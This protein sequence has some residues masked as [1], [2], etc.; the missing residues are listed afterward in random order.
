LENE[1]FIKQYTLIPDF[2]KLGYKII[3]IT[4]VKV[5]ETIS[6]EQREKARDLAKGVLKKGQYEIVM[7]ERGI[8]LGYDGVFISYHRNYSEYADLKEWFRRFEFLEVGRT[9]SFLI[10]LEDSV[11]YRPLDLTSFAHHLMMKREEE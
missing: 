1:G 8:G 9:D 5:K 6:P 7:C 2:C 4:F 3:A 10:D 11:R